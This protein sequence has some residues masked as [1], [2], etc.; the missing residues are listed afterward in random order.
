MF[1]Q[2]T[3]VLDCTAGMMGGGMMGGSG[4]T[5]ASQIRLEQ[6]GVHGLVS[7]LAASGAQAAFTLTLP[8]DSAFATLTG[9]NTIQIYQQAGTQLHG[10]STL[11]NGND[12]QVRGLLFNDSGIYRLVS[13][14]ITPHLN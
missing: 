4:S 12:V 9:V 1:S 11:A 2:S 7:A 6:Q 8:T 14:W 5:T 10:I 13:T 3:S